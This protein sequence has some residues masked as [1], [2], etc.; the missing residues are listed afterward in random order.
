M[1][2]IAVAPRRPRTL[3][4]YPLLLGVERSHAKAQVTGSLLTLTRSK[5]SYG[6]E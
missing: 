4:A 6:S 5:S 3:S 2:E 1:A